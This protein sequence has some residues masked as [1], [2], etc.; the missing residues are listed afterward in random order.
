MKN[1]GVIVLLVILSMVILLFIVRIFNSREIDD[2]SPAIGCSGDI[3]MK[4]DV[5]WVIPIFQNDSI[6]N[7]PEWCEYILS[8]NKSLGLH[9]VYHSFEEFGYSRNAG[10][11]NIGA[12]AFEKCF[13]FKPNSFKAPQ[14]I[15]SGENRRMIEEQG[16]KVKGRLNQILHKVYHC[17]DSGTFS[18]R[19]IDFF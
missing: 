5:L 9:G 19:F 2:V 1:K 16:Y 13:G 6:E 4:S 15:I 17:G 7:Y 18:N 14:L 8:F 10:Y 11:L 3:L 12:G